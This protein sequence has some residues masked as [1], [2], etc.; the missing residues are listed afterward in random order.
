MINVDVSE[1]V[2]AVG[3]LVEVRQGESLEATAYLVLNLKYRLSKVQ[4]IDSAAIHTISSQ[5]CDNTLLETDC[6]QNEVQLC[7]LVNTR[8]R[9]FIRHKIDKFSRFV[10]TDEVLLRGKINREIATLL[11]KLSAETQK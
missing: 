4:L 11:L 6:A 10:Q 9:F 8:R 2:V 1:L 3:R 5:V 7:I